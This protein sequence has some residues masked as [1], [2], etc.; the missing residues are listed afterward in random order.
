MRETRKIAAILVA[1]VV[2]YSRLMGEDET[3]TA[4]NVREHRESCSGRRGDPAPRA[5]RSASQWLI[6]PLTSRRTMSSVEGEMS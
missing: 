3:G 1:D 6:L 5:E 2:G 4:P